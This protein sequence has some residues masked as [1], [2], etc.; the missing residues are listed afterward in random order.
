MNIAFCVLDNYD[1]MLELLKEYGFSKAH[2]KRHLSAKELKARLRKSQEVFL[3]IDLIN[4]N[5]I[6]PVFT[7]VAPTI[8]EETEH[9][10]ILHKP[11]GLHGHSLRYDEH[12]NVLSWLRFSGR[13]KLLEVAKQTHERGLL[14]RLDQATSGVLVYAKAESLWQQLR[15]NFNFYTHTKRYIAIV[16]K[17]PD[18]TGRLE[19]WFDLSGKKVKTYLEEKSSLQ[20]G[21]LNLSILK[22][23]GNGCVVIIDLEHGHRHQIRAHL[24][25]LGCPIRGDV[26]YGGEEAERLFLHAYRYD[27]TIKDIKLS[28]IDPHLGFGGDFLDLHRDLE[29]LSDHG[30]IIH[31]R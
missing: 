30:G 17:T 2:M 19:A 23:D 11:A 21:H 20:L 22:N 4:N 5:Q 18:Q 27:I 26:T 6:S 1:S 12:D 31:R 28:A 25:A 9:F 16:D 13:G 29:M 14:Y 8:I 10:L 24:A 15:D 3:P 7:G